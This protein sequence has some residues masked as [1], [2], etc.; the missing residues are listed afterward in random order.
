VLRSILRRQVYVPPARTD[1]VQQNVATSTAWSGISLVTTTAIQLVRSI[2]FA[3]LLMPDDFGVLA[4]ANVLTQFVLIFANFGFNASVIYQKEVD[5]Q[6]LSTCWWSNL[7]VDG[8]VA[9]ICCIVAWFSRD[10]GPD[11]RIPWVVAMLATQFVITAV[12]SINLALMRR[13]FMF[14]KIAIINMSGALAIP[15]VA[16]TCVAGLGWGVYGLAMGLIVGN[17]VMSVLNFA[18]LP[19]LPSFSFSRERLRRHLSYGGWFL[20]VHVATYINGNLDRTLVGMRL[21]TTQLGYYEYAANIPLTVATQLSTAIN[22]VLF[23][24]FSSLQDDL[25]K[26][27]DLLRKVYRY[28]AFIVYPMLAGMALVADDFVLT[29]YGEKWIP[30]IPVLRVFC[31]VGMI[32][33]IINPLYPLCNGL[34]LPRLPF[35]WS[36]LLMPVNLAALW[37]GITH[38]G[39]M[40]AVEARI[41]V[42]VLIMFTLGREIF[43]HARFRIRWLFQALLPAVVCCGLMA[44]GVLG[45]R[46]LPLLADLPVLPRLMVQIVTGGLMYVGAMTLC[47]RQDVDSLV[48]QGKRFMKRG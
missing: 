13:Q 32:R 25:D 36:L 37:L 24:A 11:P 22:S 30:I 43:G 10:R 18:F 26:L 5:R 48:S 15:I 44:A 9:V 8:L 39:L 7:A 29:M 1:Q 3:R 35:K 38:F 14:K 31:L 21:D 4:L 23:P 27:G 47:Y 40:G 45:I 17:L 41:V 28:N 34:G 46:Q 6:D 16:A 33:I 19:W 42:P 12:G 20:G 2:I